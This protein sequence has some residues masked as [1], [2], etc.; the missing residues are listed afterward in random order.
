MSRQN[1]ISLLKRLLHYVDTRTT[2]MADAP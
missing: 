2:A 1:Q